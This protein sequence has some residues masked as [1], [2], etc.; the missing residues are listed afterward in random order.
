M[1][2]GKTNYLCGSK[3]N[4]VAMEPGVMNGKHN[5]CMNTNAN[6]YTP[7]PRQSPLHRSEFH[8]CG[9]IKDMRLCI[10]WPHLFVRS[11]L[12]R[13][14]TT[15]INTGYHTIMSISP[16]PVSATRAWRQ[17]DLL[18]C[19]SHKSLL[20][21]VFLLESSR[22]LMSE[23]CYYNNELYVLIIKPRTHQCTAKRL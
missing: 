7:L 22:F 9:M 1:Y 6:H 17:Q 8:M 5:L 11:A 13:V 21:H 23:D 10:D 16:V 2:T 20:I 12:I 15:T 14:N 4:T 18:L 19:N 3:W